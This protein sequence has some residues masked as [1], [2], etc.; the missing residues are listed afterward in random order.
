MR[1]MEKQFL[2]CDPKER[3]LKQIQKTL[4]KESQHS[5]NKWLRFNERKNKLDLALNVV[6]VR[7]SDPKQLWD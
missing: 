5:L 6:L 7:D 4:Y 2:E 1:E 3:H